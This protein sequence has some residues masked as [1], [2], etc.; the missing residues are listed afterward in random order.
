[1]LVNISLGVAIYNVMIRSPN[2]G[3]VNDFFHQ[4]LASISTTSVHAALLG[5]MWAITEDLANISFK[6]Q[7]SGA[8]GVL[9]WSHSFKHEHHM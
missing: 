1:M 9:Q 6:I 3:R 2:Q 7:R 5:A 4:V 8:R